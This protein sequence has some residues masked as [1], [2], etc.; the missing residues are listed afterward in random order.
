[1]I[2]RKTAT[3]DVHLSQNIL[4]GTCE[5]SRYCVLLNILRK[6]VNVLVCMLPLVMVS[7]AVQFV[8]FF[9]VYKM[10]GAQFSILSIERQQNYIFFMNGV[11][12]AA[13]PSGH[14]VLRTNT[15]D[16]PNVSL[17]S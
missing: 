2:E 6:Q 4:Y 7:R 15:H 1:M 14:E 16:P 11:S 17:F 12:C 10:S 5:I 9:S 8:F 13:A 3:K